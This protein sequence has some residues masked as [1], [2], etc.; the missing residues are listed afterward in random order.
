MKPYCTWRVRRLKWDIQQ[1]MCVSFMKAHLVPVAQSRSGAK[2]GCVHIEYCT[3]GR[4]MHCRHKNQAYKGK[5]AS[6]LVRLRH[7]N[8]EGR[9]AMKEKEKNL[10]S[11][12]KQSKLEFIP[13]T[14]ISWIHINWQN[15]FLLSN[16]V[17]WSKIQCKPFSKNLC[18]TQ[19]QPSAVVLQN[20]FHLATT[21]R[22]EISL[23]VLSRLCS[24]AT[25]TER[26][27]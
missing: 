13:F 23:Y 22:Q 2:T 25:A 10:G 26:Q 4:K 16:A 7:K 19:K 17:W 1:W 5:W 9:A 6:L 24:F 15:I 18:A 11:S 27:F 3:K 12:G 20:G 8:N 14:L 21:C